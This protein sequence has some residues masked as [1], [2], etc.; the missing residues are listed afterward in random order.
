M[1]SGA[2]DAAAIPEDMRTGKLDMSDPSNPSTA[3]RFANAALTMMG[4]G[5]LF[6]PSGE[7]ILSAG[8]RRT[9]A[10]PVAAAPKILSNSVPT[11]EDVA[12]S[13]AGARS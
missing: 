13:L 2:K 3:G 10:A 11:S 12:R 7:A 5:G 9:T 8:A 4:L 1:W 6:A